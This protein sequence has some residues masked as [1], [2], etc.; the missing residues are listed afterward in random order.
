MVDW[1]KKVGSNLQFETKQF[2]KTY[3][4]HCIVL[5][6]MPLVGT[7]LRVDLINLT[8]RYA[9]EVQGIQHVKYNPFFFKT[10]TNW[11]R[12]IVRDC[13]KEKWLEANGFTLIEVFTD[14]VPKLSAAFIQEK[15]G[16]S[17]V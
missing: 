2:F 7:K 8:Y 5:E 12:A 17:L 14:E 16:I 4:E 13:E 6:E 9:V 10:R 11:A 3:W 1:D 15:Y